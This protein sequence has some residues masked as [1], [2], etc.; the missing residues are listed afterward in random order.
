MPVR[1][2][3]ERGNPA[4]LEQIG[5]RIAALQRVL[6]EK[7]MDAALIYDHE[8]LI[9]FTGAVDLEGSVLCIPA[10]GEAELLCPAMEARHIRE[11]TGVKTVTPYDFP[12]ANESVSA[13]QWVASLGKKAPK[14][15]FTRYFIT[16]KDYLCLRQEV[17]EMQV[18]DLA[19][20]CYRIRSVKSGEEIARIR[21]AAEILGAGMEAAVR[22]VR[23]GVKEYEVL[24]EADYAM[25]K[26]GSQGASFRMQV[27]RHDRQMLMHPYAGDYV[28]GND[29]PV[30]I[31]LGSS[32]D[33][34]TAKMCRTVFLGA[35]PEETRK[36]YA[37][38][39]EAQK[40]AVSVL[41]PGVLCGEVYDAAYGRLER[42]GYGGMW[43]PYAGYGVGIRQSEFYPVIE[44]GSKTPLL[45][46]MVI[47]L[48]LPTIYL[49]GF[50]GPRI[51][52]T[53]L[54][55]A[56]GGE[57]LSNYSRGPIVKTF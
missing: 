40:A 33:G 13:A 2:A 28:L 38:L 18:C 46:N 34:Y 27:L 20:D 48:L 1:T 17:P 6:K 15:G 3:A 32:V 12:C 50:G 21:R 23:P 57:Y 31:H 36:I 24:A 41:K 43:I 55:T 14:V 51:T 30:V 53:I 52:D 44:K 56:E 54:I 37:A 39:C 42:L 45:E 35:V 25:R 29:E 8:N 9:Y 11:S 47:D 49:P 7:D 4:V 22:F 26:A 5:N 19:T 16:L 10:S